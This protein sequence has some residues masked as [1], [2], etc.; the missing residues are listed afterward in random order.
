MRILPIQIYMVHLTGDQ[1]PI[2]T[3]SNT[4]QA[5]ARR[6]RA[7]RDALVRATGQDYGY[8]VSRWHQYLSSSQSPEDI[9]VEYTWSN[10]HFQ[11]EDWKPDS[12]WHLAVDEAERLALEFPN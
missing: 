7:A 11:F 8:D 10:L 9:Y 1:L 3:D 2:E 5:R 12:D 4:V 6:M